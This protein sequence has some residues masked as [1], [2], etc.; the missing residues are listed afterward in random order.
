[1]WENCTWSIY[2]KGGQQSTSKTL[3]EFCAKFPR[4]APGL[5]RV[6]RPIPD[7]ESLPELCYLPFDETPTVTSSDS[8][9]E[10]DD[11]QPRAQ[12][13]KIFRNGTLAV[14]DSE[15]IKTFSKTF[16]VEEKISHKQVP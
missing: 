12:A 2:R 14:D 7:H 15:S 8:Q 16:V 6:P 5:E 1:M 4:S 9:Q 13:K 3:W 10:A 11:Y